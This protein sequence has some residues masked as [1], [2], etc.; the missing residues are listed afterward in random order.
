[1]DLQARY[2]PPVEPCAPDGSRLAALLRDESRLDTGAVS[3]GD[4]EE[5]LRTVNSLLSEVYAYTLGYRDGLCTDAPDPRTE[6]AI[7]RIKIQLE[8]ELLWALRRG[9]PATPGGLPAVP[10]GLPAV[11]GGLLTEPIPDGQ[12]AVADYLAGLA[13]ANRAVAHPLFGY[14]RDR[15]TVDQV[16][17]FLWAE[18]IRNEYV[19]DEVALLAVGL[20]GR[21]KVTVVANLWDECGRGRLVNFHTYWLRRLIA[22]GPGGWEGFREYRAGGHPWFAGITSNVFMLLLTRPALKMA[23]YGTFLLNESWVEPHFE[24][25]IAGLRRLGITDDDTLIYFKAHV[26]IDPRHSAELIDGVR[27]QVPE[28]TPAQLERIVLGARLAEAAACLAYDRWLA[29]L[30]GA[31]AR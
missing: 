30:P 26:T 17:M 19:D 22:A 13:A 24:A 29:L 7:L 11:P 2:W 14:L 27:G 6:S 31:G 20:Q 4:P 28:L 3:R 5:H 23:A 18:T 9:L 1:M 21:Q 25:I 10:G 8:D 16:R 15:A 12:A